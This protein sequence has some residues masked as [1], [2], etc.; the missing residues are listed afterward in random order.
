MVGLVPLEIPRRFREGVSAVLFLTGLVA[1]PV[2]SKVPERT[3][4]GA[5]RTKELSIYDLRFT[6]YD[7]WD[8][9]GGGEIRHTNGG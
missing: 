3:S 2:R 5:G 8:W 7:F 6:I 4:N 9:G 1:G